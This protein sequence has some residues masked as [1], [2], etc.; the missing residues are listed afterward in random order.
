MEMLPILVF[1]KSVAD[2]HADNFASP[3]F[4]LMNDPE[5]FAI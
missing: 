4:Y 2:D 5:V 3:Q 1:M